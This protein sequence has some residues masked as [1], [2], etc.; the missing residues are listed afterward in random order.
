[1]PLAAPTLAHRSSLRSMRSVAAHLGALLA[2]LPALPVP[3][4]LPGSLPRV[5]PSAAH[6]LSPS[7]AAGLGALP[8]FAPSLLA[9]CALARPL[10]VS[11][12]TPPVT[13]CPL[14][15]APVAGTLP[16]LR[17]VSFLLDHAPGVLLPLQ[18]RQRDARRRTLG[19]RGADVL[20][21]PHGEGL[22][23]ERLG[24]AGVGVGGLGWAR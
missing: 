10:C 17:A 21:P 15:R 13:S 14:L 3:W 8:A 2:P 20:R 23:G 11:L 6:A 1:M 24:G 18:L 22:A 19:R 5:A 7:A 9:A 16:C 12:G 4:P